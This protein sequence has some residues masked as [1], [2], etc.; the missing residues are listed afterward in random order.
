VMLTGDNDGTARAIARET[1]VDEVRSELL[2]EDKLKGIPYLH[3]IIHTP[4]RTTTILA[5]AIYT[6]QRQ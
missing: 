4:R 2:P 1:G 6:P 3:K 5:L